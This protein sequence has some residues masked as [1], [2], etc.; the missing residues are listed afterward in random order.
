MKGS[1]ID[2]PIRILLEIVCLLE[3][4][5]MPFQ[6][7][8]LCDWDCALGTWMLMTSMSRSE[9]GNPIVE[10]NKNDQSYIFLYVILTRSYKGDLFYFLL[11]WQNQIKV[12]PILT[13]YFP[14]NFLQRNECMPYA[15]CS[16]SFPQIWNSASKLDYLLRQ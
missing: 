2:I 15:F 6:T 7:K 3:W 10:M 12:N 11:S 5:I 16:V 13:K 9:I 8:S 1:L 4:K 14:P